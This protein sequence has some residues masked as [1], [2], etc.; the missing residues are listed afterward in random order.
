[1]GTPIDSEKNAPVGDAP[2]L[3]AI[4]TVNDASLVNAVGKIKEIVETWRGARGSKY[5]QVVTWRDLWK[6]GLIAFDR[7]GNWIFNQTDGAVQGT[8]IVNSGQG[9]R[10]TLESEIRNSRAFKELFQ[11]INSPE[12]LAEFP[13]EVRAAL[14]RDLADVAKEFGAAI[15]EMDTIIQNQ[16]RSFAMRLQE[17]TASVVGAQAGVRALYFA[18]ATKDRAQAGLITQVRA[19]LDDF[20]GTGVTVEQKMVATVDRIDGLKGTYTVKIDANGKFAG[21]TLAV[22]APVNAQPLSQ[23][24]INADQLSFFS[25]N[26]NVSPFGADANG[27]YMN[28]AV[29]INT[30]GGL[31]FDQLA[32]NAS[33]PAITFI[34]AFASAPL[35]T[36]NNVY[37]NTTDG[38]SY[39]HNGTGWQVY[40]E[41]GAR[42]SVTLYGTGVWSN[43]AAD[44]LILNATGKP[45][46]TIGDTVTI[47]NATSATTKYWSGTGWIDPGVVIN[48]N[49]L[50]D[51]TMSASKLTAGTV[52]VPSVSSAVTIGPD[53]S[54]PAPFN[55]S[56]M[57][58][59]RTSGIGPA[60]SI[61]NQGSGVGLYVFSQGS[62]DGI[63]SVAQG[64]YGGAFTSQSSAYSAVWARNVNGGHAI[65]AYGGSGGAV[66][67]SA[68]IGLSDGRC[69]YNEGGTFG[70]FTGAHDAVIP[71][72]VDL[73]M[74]EGDIV[75]DYQLAE[76]NGVSD[77]IF[78]VRLSDRPM[79][80]TALGV[81]NT[82]AKRFSIVPA[83]F[84][85]HDH[86][87]ID[88][89]QMAQAKESFA[90]YLMNYDL[91]TVNSVGEGQINV[92]G[93]N[94]DIEAGDLI[95]TSS[96]RGKGMRQS[97]DLV[98][99]YTVAKAREA[100]V[101]TQPNE[102]KLIGCIY[103][104]G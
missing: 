59:T 47:S 100:V 31:T 16:S 39:I 11:R 102:I 60:S 6:V 88:G 78:D 82:R 28:G 13:D 70:P 40:L 61:F 21:F 90:D 7:G 85:D 32:H 94:G 17:I 1:M 97:D 63:F 86:V 34:G 65:R 46:K 10:S 56:G 64:G 25:A 52:A 87:G 79:Q 42:G 101:F 95:V 81:L 83:A 62:G 29:R 89:Q 67:S 66:T 104:C 38:K 14:S 45:E 30:G 35:G 9:M 71:K 2:N 72:D 19:R 37:R 20:G 77:T 5:E 73:D 12:S 92:C 76:R 49:L 58:I 54:A 80:K 51:G 26:G 22:D 18:S 36:K 69:F 96:K 91:L 41:A 27:I 68:I 53:S 43:A 4:P 99:N 75:V 3:P 55:N 33:T 15:R 57:N 8:T 23:F 48:G 74:V 84:I 24:I 44:S 50:V 98:H 103:L 93:E